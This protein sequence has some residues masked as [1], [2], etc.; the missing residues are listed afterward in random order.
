MVEHLR[1]FAAASG[2]AEWARVADATYGLIATMQRNYSPQTGLLPDF[3][4]DVGDKPAPAQPNYLE[5]A[6]DGR[7][8]YNA[9]RAP[10]R[11]ATD[12]LLNGDRR[13]LAALQPIDAWA[14][15]STG[16][17]PERIVGGYQL[18]GTATADAYELA[19]AAPLG[20][21][22]MV[23]ADN[24]DW[25]NAL[26]DTVAGSSVQGYY[27]DSLKLLSMLVM[28]GNWWSPEN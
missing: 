26:W 16:G 14:R 3:I 19:F 6:S 25:L 21:G 8:A 18:D 2:D 17:K 15:A 9:C 28:S 11:I 5:N 1:A 7:Y 22:A 4:Q 24:Q 10:W 23:S 27:P 13:A 12:Y 20:V